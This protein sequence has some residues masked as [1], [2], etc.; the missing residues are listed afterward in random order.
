VTEPPDGADLL[1]RIRAARVRVDDT[2]DAYRLAV[3]QRNR[4]LLA[5][6]DEGYSSQTLAAAAGIDRKTLLQA[7][8]R[9][10]VD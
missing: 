1:E 9:A 3:E 2:R 5:A 10:D 4:L 7:V 6:T 8:I